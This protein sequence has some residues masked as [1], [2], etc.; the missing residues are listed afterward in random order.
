M[1]CQNCGA[2]N[3]DDALFCAYC[4]KPIALMQLPK[5]QSQMKLKNKCP[6]CGADNPVGLKYCGKCGEKILPKPSS[7]MTYDSDTQDDSYECSECGADVAAKDKFCSN[8]GEPLEDDDT[9]Q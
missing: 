9:P 3:L 2:E 5:S 8:C 4:A 7:H 6:H 1:K